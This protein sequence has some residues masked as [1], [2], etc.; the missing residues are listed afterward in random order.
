MNLLQ[1]LFLAIVQG[2]TEFFPVSSSG[3]LVMFQVLFGLEEPQVF[4]DAMLHFGTLLALL[5]FLRKDLL[6]IVRA[7]WR[8]FTR[9]E[10][11]LRDNN[12]KLFIYLVIASIPTGIMGY[13]LDDFFESMF[14]SMRTVGC[15]LLVTSIVLFLTRWSREK[16]SLGTPAQALLI[17]VLQGMAITPGFSRSGF[18]IAGGLLLGW[19]RE[20]AT[21]FSFLLS[22]PAIMGA[23]LYQIHKINWAYPEWS[24]V[25][26]GVLVSALVGY[27]SL[28]YL[29]RLVKKGKFYLFSFYCLSLGFLALFLSFII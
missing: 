18:T 4:V 25:G 14:S 3:H 28:V 21:R 9:K 1:I 5:A 10:N 13:F 15:A 29:A 26:A 19:K 2:L 11:R 7:L 20:E 16:Q 24:K 6:A 23:G 27:F 8:L 12:L 22:I 17:G